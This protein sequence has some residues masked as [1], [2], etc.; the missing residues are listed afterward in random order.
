MKGKY[1]SP[2]YSQTIIIS[3]TLACLFILNSPDIAL[4]DAGGLEMIIPLLGLLMIAGRT[5][6][7][8]AGIILLSYVIFKHTKLHI[9]YKI[10]LSSV[11]SLV[12]LALFAV[13]H[14]GFFLL[15]AS[16]LGLY[17]IK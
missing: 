7:V 8:I 17:E 16:Y 10:L 11:I 15:I 2:Q 9:A 13:K 14:G 12:F 5:L 3:S 4:A 1:T 6:I